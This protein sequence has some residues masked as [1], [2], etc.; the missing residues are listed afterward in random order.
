MKKLSFLFL[1]AV[2]SL[3]TTTIFAQEVKEE[4][5]AMATKAVQEKVEI[6]LSEL[7][8]SVTKVLGEEFA[9]FTA[10][11]AYKAKKENKDIFHVKLEKE[12]KYTLVH[13]DSDGNVLGKKEFKEMKS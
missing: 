13:F 1:F 8:E 6:K 5:K 10:A 9:D 7:P 11:K 4:V 2:L 3:C 12:G